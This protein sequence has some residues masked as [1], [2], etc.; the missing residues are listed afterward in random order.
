MLPQSRVQISGRS[1]S[2]WARRSLAPAMSVPTGSGGSGASAPPSTRSPPMPAVRLRT[3]ST[4]L[5]RTR[6]TTSRKSFGS[7]APRPVWGSRTWMCAIAAPAICT[8]VT[9]MRSLRPAVSPA[10]VTAQVTK[11]SQFIR[12][13]SPS[14]QNQRDLV[15]EAERGAAEHGQATRRHPVPGAPDVDDGDRSLET[16]QDGRRDPVRVVLELADAGAEATPPHF[17]QDGVEL[18]AVGHG[19]LGVPLQMRRQDAVPLVLR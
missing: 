11:T 12:P 19:A 1:S 14:F 9:G 3:T 2:T 4:S 5:E 17:G 10:P 16:V 15:G 7:R 6:S 18:I 13:A 8:G